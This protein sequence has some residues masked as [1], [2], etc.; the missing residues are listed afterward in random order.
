LVN[1]DDIDLER[2]LLHR[3]MNPNEEEITM[4]KNY[5]PLNIKVEKLDLGI[6]ENYKITRQD[7]KN[8]TDNYYFETEKY[9]YIISFSEYDDKY[10]SVSFKAKLPNEYF[11]N[12]NVI[13]NENPYKILNTV[14]T[15]IKD[16]YIKKI[17][18]MERICKKYNIP[19]DSKKYIKG[20]VFS[21][22]GDKN[23]NLQR[24]NFYKRYFNSIGIDVEFSVK[25]NIYYLSII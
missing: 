10:Y 23:K 14:I 12:S 13:T 9:D 5:K 21:F 11:F 4:K 22:V 3:V 2:T 8:S 18:E 17:E 7:K 20:F 1:K 16:F 6:Y 19:F 15:T 24:L 25:D